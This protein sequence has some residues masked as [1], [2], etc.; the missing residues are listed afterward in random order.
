MDELEDEYVTDETEFDLDDDFDPCSDL[1]EIWHPD[2][3][4]T[5]QFSY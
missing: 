4:D 3:A 2:V 5:F 1:S